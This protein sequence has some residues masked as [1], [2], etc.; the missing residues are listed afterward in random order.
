MKDGFKEDRFA[1]AQP[2]GHSLARQPTAHRQRREGVAMSS[3]PHSMSHGSPQ[4]VWLPERH[5][6]ALV[7]CQG[8]KGGYVGFEILTP[9]GAWGV[10]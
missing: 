2:P 7:S 10:V 4:V 3:V 1:S 8:R 6:A 9:P 5:G